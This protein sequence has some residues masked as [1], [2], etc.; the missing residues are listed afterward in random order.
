MTT[1]HPV[2][3]VVNAGSSSV[4]ISIFSVPEAAHEDVE[5][6]PAQLA[7]GQIEGI[8][9][10]PHIEGKVRDKL[11]ALTARGVAFRSIYAALDNSIMKDPAP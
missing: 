4:K 5:V 7:H 10:A 6:L 1:A 9:V 3:L 11:A 2:I 8:G